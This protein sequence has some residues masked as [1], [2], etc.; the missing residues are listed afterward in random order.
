[1]PRIIIQTDVLYGENPGV[2]LSERVVAAN[3][4]S[5]HYATHLIQRLSWA[6]ADAEAIEAPPAAGSNRAPADSNT[7]P[8]VELAAAPSGI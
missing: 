4:Q 1:M 3:L 7:A 6:T 8:A 2:T 5:P